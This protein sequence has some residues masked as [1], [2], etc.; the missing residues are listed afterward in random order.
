MNKSELIK[1]VSEQVDLPKSKT[2]EVITAIFDA[3]T[4]ALT[5]QERISLI[6]FGSF[7]TVQK[8]ARLGHNPKDGSPLQ[9]AA[10]VV[11][12]FKAGANLKLSVNST[13]TETA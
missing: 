3:I 11:P 1:Q 2:N 8:P 12:K 13:T 5:N 9:I 7:S 6:G 10:K 4:S